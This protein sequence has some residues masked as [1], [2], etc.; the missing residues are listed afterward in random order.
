MAVVA[1]ER[2]LNQG[3]EIKVLC[4]FK[5]PC[6]LL[7]GDTCGICTPDEYSRTKKEEK[8]AGKEGHTCPPPGPA[9]SALII[10]SKSWLLR[11]ECLRLP[12]FGDSDPAFCFPGLVP[13]VTDPPSA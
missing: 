4:L 13:F 11:R 10:I 9:L 5:Q 6:V 2:I 1:G 7:H 12:G 3:G 8:D